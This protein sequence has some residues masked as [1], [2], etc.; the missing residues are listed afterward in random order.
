MTEKNRT[1]LMKLSSSFP[2]QLLIA[3]AVFVI[4]LL[5][6]L[7]PNDL[8][9]FG[10]LL[11]SL[12]AGTIICMGLSF[13]DLFGRTR[14]RRNI[15]PALAGILVITV[16]L[17]SAGNLMLWNTQ[18]FESIS[19]ARTTLS[20]QSAMATVLFTF[21]FLSMLIFAS[22]K[23]KLQTAILLCL[24]VTAIIFRVYP[25]LPHSSDMAGHLISMDDPYFHYKQTERLYELGDVPDRDYTIYPPEGRGTPEKFPY[26]YNTYLAHL[27][28]IPLHHIILLYPIFFSMLGVIALY[29]F[30][31][32]MTG[33][34]KSATLA[35]FFFAT[36]PVLLSK[37]FA[38]AIEEDLMGLVLAI[39]SMFF[40]LKAARSAGK[41]NVLYSIISGLFFLVTLVTWK[42]ITFL[43]AIPI[44]AFGLYAIFSIAI[45]L[46]T[47]YK[48]SV[49]NTTRAG[50]IAGAIPIIGNFLFV[51]FGS[52][53]L[54]QVA[55]YGALL[56]FGLLAEVLQMRSGAG[57]KTKFSIE[58]NHMQTALMA[59]TVILILFVLITGLDK[60]INLPE[61]TLET[62]A[63]TTGHNFLVDK[64]ISEQAALASGSLAEKLSAG[65]DRYGIAEYLSLIMAFF[66]PI[67][68]GYYFIKDKEKM[69]FYMR[70]YLVSA[71][72]FIIAMTFVWVEAR[73][74]FSQS[75]GFLLLGAMS[76]L[77]IPGSPKEL[78]SIKIVSIVLIILIFGA[79]FIPNL[80]D[81]RSWDR[82]FQRA[83]VD[84]AWFLGVKWLDENIEQGTFLPGGGYDSGDY[85]LT[86]W[87]YG[88]FIT[89]LSDA[90]V[91]ADPLQ[92]RE[93]YI[94]QIARFFYN[95]TTE[96]EAMDWLTSQPW[97]PKDG[98]DDYKVKY[99]ILDYS[100]VG[101][102]SALAFLGT[103]YY[104]V[105]NNEI[106]E[107]GRCSQGEICQNI[108][109]GLVAQVIDD[110]YVCEE[111]VVCTKDRLTN[112]EK[113]MCC[114][115]DP[116]QC[117]DMSFDWHVIGDENGSAKLLRSPG[118]PV[119]GQYMLETQKSVCRSEFRTSTDPIVLVENGERTIVSKRY[120]YTGSS[121]LPYA[122]GV[123][124][125]A[126]MISIYSD[127]TQKT[128]LIS[129]NCQ[130]ADAQEIMSQGKDGLVNVGYGMRLGGE[131][132]PQVFI[133]VPS[134]WM[135]NM[136]TEL[137]L[138]DAQDLDHFELV[139]NEE[140]KK[141]YPSVKIFKVSYGANPTGGDSPVEN[142]GATVAKKG[143]RV[144]VDYTLRLENGTIQESSKGKEPFVFTLG[145]GEA[146]AGF[147][148]AVVGMEVGETK[149]IRVPPEQAYG[150]SGSH[151]LANKTLFFELE[152]LS[153]NEDTTSFDI[154][155]LGL[156]DEFEIDK[157]PTVVIDC[158]LAKEG[159]FAEASAELD[160]LGKLVCIQ[161]KGQ[162]KELCG[163]FG[164]QYDSESG[165]VA[166]SNTKD[167][168]EKIRKISSD[169]CDITGNKTSI[170]VFGTKDCQACEKQKDVL[171]ILSQ[172][173]EDSIE[174]SYYCMGDKDYCTKRSDITV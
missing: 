135:K 119:Y 174:L 52:I 59:L 170:M 107:D 28:G 158:K 76:G 66:I 48:H 46:I 160:A 91:I 140:T 101:K 24:I 62:F 84:P 7:I 147:D 114:V 40:L 50:L 96:S 173:F 123:Y 159:I 149:T 11:L 120:L 3:T 102:A 12:F 9:L 145:A 23:I 127:G 19:Q 80:P 4:L 143:D 146:I 77:L 137:Y 104:Q 78:G 139:L 43:Y 20:M 29:F 47:K 93:D 172:L 167:V 163:G 70:A 33:D 38:G 95:S 27:T 133:H 108:E 65:Y 155:D 51:R 129:N 18:D 99:I 8:I 165:L 14:S 86:W 44:T 32:E 132:V 118:T 126:F 15:L 164:I 39:V 61:R 89:S 2:I 63:G 121:G 41:E 122:D 30:V 115:A 87:D 110:K 58:R 152:L 25:A 103:N 105:P 55:P 17:T 154:Y 156:V 5:W 141:F 31:R 90:T 64:T 134:K 67:L 60:I 111:G 92:A 142:S 54:T 144:A 109:N 128:T 136:F 79:V 97:N 82:A 124:Y 22:K 130:T 42:G 125:P 26:Y 112:V 73:L 153:I 162:P 106:A 169:A 35:G 148:S 151:P 10:L 75:L 138:F 1:D 74:A 81:T 37:S 94:M 6:L 16:I 13:M 68:L 161:S 157:A 72:F 83:G 100:L 131:A 36:M 69:F 45:L 88:H 166:D 113:K 98:P 56:F 150:T 168:L 85:V 171:S 34:W 53:D 57:E 117:C 116:K 21:Y 49:W 71:V